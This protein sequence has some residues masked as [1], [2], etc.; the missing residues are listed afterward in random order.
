MHAHVS[1]AIIEPRHAELYLAGWIAAHALN[2]F[3]WPSAPD[4]QRVSVSCRPSGW[5]CRAKPCQQSQVSVVRSAAKRTRST[6]LSVEIHAG[7]WQSATHATPST[8]VIWARGRQKTEGRQP[9]VSK[10]S[11]LFHILNYCGIV[12]F[13]CI[14]REKQAHPPWRHS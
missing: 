13:F 7:L 10:H 4:V 1:V 8:S 3:A 6:C 5:R 2:M 12:S 14:V 11:S 9:S